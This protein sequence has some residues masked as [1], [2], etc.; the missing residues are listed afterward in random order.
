M[1]TSVSLLLFSKNTSI[2]RIALTADLTGEFSCTTNLFTVE[3]NQDY[4]PVFT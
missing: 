1:F 3:V 2:N 4:E